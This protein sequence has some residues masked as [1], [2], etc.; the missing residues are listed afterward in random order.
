[1]LVLKIF[2]NLLKISVPYEVLDKSVIICMEKAKREG[3]ANV[4]LMKL[5]QIMETKTEFNID[6]TPFFKLIYNELYTM[7]QKMWLD[8]ITSSSGIHAVT[9]ELTRV[10]RALFL[11]SD[12]NIFIQ[13]LISKNISNSLRNIQ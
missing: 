5:K 8:G 6:Q 3:E 10:F 1:M 4:E 13:R 7:K 2:Q 9:N 11:E 12:K